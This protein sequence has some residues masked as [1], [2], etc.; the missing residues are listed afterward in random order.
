VTARKPRRQRRSWGKILQ[1]KSGRWRASYT[2]PDTARHAAPATFGTKLAAE[3][4]LADERRLIENGEWTPPA[5]RAAQKYARAMAFGD[6][7]EKWIEHRN[8]KPRTRQ[9]YSELLAGPLASLQPMPLNLLTPEAVRAWHASQ[10]SATPTRRAHA[11]GLLHAILATALADGLITSNP[12][13]I[14][15]AMRATPQR[16][17]TVLTPEQIGKVATEIRADLRAAVLIAAWCGTRF[18]ELVELRRADIAADASVIAVGRACTHRAGQCT[19]STPKSGRGRQVVV[20]PHVRADILDHLAAHV[21]P[22][23]DAML[24]PG[25]LPACGHMPDR[26]F[27]DY[28]RAALKA[29]G[30]PETIR[31]HDLRHTAATTAAR[32]G[33]LAEVQARLGHSTVNAAMRY[34]HAAASRDAELAEQLSA[35]VVV[36]PTD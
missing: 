8:V 34:Q 24:F 5:F 29:V 23:A 13:Q 25:T 15:G 14:R 2:G 18:G 3:G 35:L 32:F 10:G 17:A 31:I 19:V 27:R 16:Q 28:Y 1:E 30:L 33:T 12:A 9:G 26:T 11:Y 7:A 4:W 20:P 6:Y 21:G 22:E 36:P